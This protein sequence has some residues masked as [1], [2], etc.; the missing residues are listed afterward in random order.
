MY[1]Q[2]AV[3]DQ[4]VHYT[5]RARR[6][7]RAE[8]IVYMINFFEQVKEESNFLFFVRL[9]EPYHTE[10]TEHHRN[11]RHRLRLRPSLAAESKAIENRQDDGLI[12]SRKTMSQIEQKICTISTARRCR[13]A[14]RSRRAGSNATCACACAVL[15]AARRAVDEISRGHFSLSSG[16]S[17]VAGITVLGRRLPTPS[18]THQLA[19]GTVFVYGVE[20]TTMN[21]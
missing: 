8:V 12:S 17:A 21:Q 1:Q 6:R 9:V 11:T 4:T 3:I 7:R 16:L 14:A 2:Q 5:S 18:C 15:A 20:S 13:H 19:N 10:R